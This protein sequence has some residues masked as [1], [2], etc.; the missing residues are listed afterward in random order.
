[1]VLTAYIRIFV[2]SSRPRGISLLSP[3]GFTGSGHDGMTTPLRDHSIA[4]AW[5]QP[6]V[7]K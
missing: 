4:E 5:L 7:S 2:L 1:M 3:W 6:V